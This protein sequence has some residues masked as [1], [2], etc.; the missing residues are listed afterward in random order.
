MA[1]VRTAFLLALLCPW[2]AFAQ[3][4][5]PAP[6]EAVEERNKALARGFFEDLWF[7]KR[8]DRYDRYVADEYVVHDIG[9]R[10]GV[11]EPAIEQ[12]H[13]AD[14]FHANGTMTGSIDYQIAEGDLVATRWQW[15][16]Q[17]SSWRFRIMGGREQIPIINVF[18]I[19]DGKIVEIWNHR[20]DI[21]TG[22]GNFAFV[23]GLGIGLFVALLGWGTAFVLWR[24]GRMARKAS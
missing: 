17:P 14:F 3:S 6:G 21:D 7:S 4:P 9:D 19:R 18:R 15:R 24:R 11:V 8:T 1:R 22:L 12:K 5:D 2:P 16:F 23:R 13:I 20:H 10:K